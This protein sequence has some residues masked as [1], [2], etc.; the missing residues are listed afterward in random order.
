M[1]SRRL[2]SYFFSSDARTF[3]LCLSVAEIQIIDK[4]SVE[5]KK[6]VFTKLCDMFTNGKTDYNSLSDARFQ[7]NK[8]IN[9]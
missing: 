8:Q 5:D 6:K 9:N 1:L 2:D 3:Q 4:I 7:T